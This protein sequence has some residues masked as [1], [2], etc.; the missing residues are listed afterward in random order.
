MADLERDSPGGGDM[1]KI[2]CAILI[3]LLLVCWTGLSS[4]AG[5]ISP[6][7]EAN[8]RSLGPGEEV[9]V[10][11]S[12]A[13]KADLK[14]FKEEK[15]KGVR[16]GK[17]IRAL[18]S[19]ADYSQKEL[20]QFL[21]NKKAKKVQSLWIFNGL[22]VTASSSVIYDLTDQPGVESIRL[23]KAVQAPEPT[24]A[25]TASFEW[26]L[27]AIR[28]PELWTMG[29]TGAGVVVANMDTGVDGQHPDLASQYRGGNNSW[30]DPNGEHITTPYDADGHGTQTMGLIVGGN[31]GGS[32]IGVAPAAQWIAV[33]I[34]NDAGQATYSGIHQAF[35]WL[36]DPDGNPTSNDAPDLVN[37]SWTL[38]GSEGQCITEFQG[39]IQALKAAEIA[40]VFS[41][42][43]VGPNPDSSESPAN[44]P[45]SFAVGAT[46]D[47]NTIDS[48]SSRGPSACDSGIYPQVVA[49][50]VN[51]K[52]AD[53]TFGGLFPGSYAYVSGTSFAAPH[54]AGAMALLLS[55]FPDA[56]VVEL[57]T[58][59]KDSAFDLGP[60]GPD[61]DYGYG[62]LDVVEAYS[63]LDQNPP[64]CTEE[65]KHDGIDQDCNGYDLTIDIIKAAYSAS[66]DSLSV[67]ATSSLGK[68][69][70][71]VLEGHGSMKWNRKKA[72][73]AITVSGVGG[74]PGTVTVS[75][76]EGS[77]TAQTSTDSGGGNG[78]GGN[79]GGKGGGK[80]KKKN[81]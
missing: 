77:E 70:S 43:N 66:N 64:Q 78:G 3:V 55:S 71:L 24:P 57:E 41:G 10:I 25:A 62:L 68:D 52:S 6:E 69:A 37:N 32:A 20:K 11:V 54:V 27:D 60:A 59:L 53:L 28:A 75:G 13:D 51:V 44:N 79:G 22:A 26:N 33:K 40:V 61:E 50:G 19:T 58:A 2:F 34:F 47:T 39:D 81:K 67:E 74:D 5:V 38:R 31:G 17:L 48:S 76:N 35:Q 12:L 72:K 29:Y 1:R 73:W 8:L 36:L 7:L 14:A 42:G 65:I 49:P 23:D 21:I 45:G 15:D 46:D 18:Q 9:A 16:R 63:L 30:F 56:M 4:E 80:G